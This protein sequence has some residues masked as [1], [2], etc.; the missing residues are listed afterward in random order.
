MDFQIGDYIHRDS[1]RNVYKK[2][3]FAIEQAVK[4]QMGSRGVVLF[5]L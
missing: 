4:A 1:I 5:F 3:K 2:E